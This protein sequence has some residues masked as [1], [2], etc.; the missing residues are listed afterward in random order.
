MGQLPR[1]GFDTSTINA[2]E[3]GGADS[4]ALIKAMRSGYHA[5]LSGVNADEILSTPLTKGPRRESL[6]VV[7]QRL[8][9]FGECLWPPNYVIELLATEYFKNPSGFSWQ[10]V[11]VRARVY[12]RSIIERDF[13]NAL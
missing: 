12:E 8:L 3:R 4:D 9:G 5:V 6:V 11:D 1:I 7:F 10:S 2:L 13:T